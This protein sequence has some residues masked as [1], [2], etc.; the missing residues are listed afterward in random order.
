MVLFLFYRT[1]VVFYGFCF[2]GTVFLGV[3]CLS[4]FCGFCIFGVFL[5]YRSVVVFCG[6]CFCGTVFFGVFFV[7][8]VCCGFCVFVKLFLYF[9]FLELLIHFSRISKAKYI[10]IYKRFFIN[11]NVDIKSFFKLRIIQ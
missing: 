8:S 1:V 3:F 10:I 9:Y 4:V 7:L 5:F 2:C 11:N 6:F